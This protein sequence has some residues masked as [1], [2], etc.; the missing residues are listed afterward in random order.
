M[1]GISFMVGAGLMGC[2]SALHLALRG[3]SVTVIERHHAGRHAS[4]VNAGGVRRLGRHPA[5]IPLSV[6]PGSVR[7]GTSRVIECALSQLEFENP[8]AGQLDRDTP[9]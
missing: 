4:G 1:F 9:R 6:L 5:E 8:A 7:P 3:K 2:S